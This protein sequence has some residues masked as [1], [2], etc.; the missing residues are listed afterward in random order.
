MS[1][2]LTST[3]LTTPQN[4]NGNYVEQRMLY[5]IRGLLEGVRAS[6][7]LREQEG[8][9]GTIQIT[10]LYAKQRRVY[11]CWLGGKQIDL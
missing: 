5:P 2:S 3:S 8:Q 1:V 11:L 10:H 6:L 4:V 9:E 7:D